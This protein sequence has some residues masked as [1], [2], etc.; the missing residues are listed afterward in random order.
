MEHALI[1]GARPRA[2]ILRS[3]GIVRGVPFIKCQLRFR[4]DGQNDLTALVT[5]PN[6]APMYWPTLLNISGQEFSDGVFRFQSC[7]FKAREFR[8]LVVVHDALTTYFAVKK[9][10]GHELT[11]VKSPAFLTGEKLAGSVPEPMR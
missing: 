3:A 10:S 5:N 7:G 8:T 4:P 2:Q 1:L 11:P 9:I 6:R